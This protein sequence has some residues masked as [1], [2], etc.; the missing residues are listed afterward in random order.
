M[1]E[2]IKINIDE[3]IHEQQVTA[4]LIREGK[5]IVE[6]IPLYRRLKINLEELEK[7][8]SDFSDE[9]HQCEEYTEGIIC[10]LSSFLDNSSSTFLSPAYFLNNY[11][12]ILIEYTINHLNRKIHMDDY[13][14]FK[15]ISTINIQSIFISIKCLLDRLVP[16]MSYFYKGI[17]LTS[18]FGRIKESNKSSGLMG[19]VF[20]NKESD[21]LFKYIYDQYN[22]WIKDIVVP[23]DI[24][25]HYNDMGLREHPTIDNRI[26]IFHVENKIFDKEKDEEDLFD[27]P[28]E[29]YYKS[30]AE[31]VNHIYEFYDTVFSLLKD[32]D[33]IYTKHHFENE[34]FYKKYMDM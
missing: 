11:I 16:I 25:M 18:T 12:D 6:D 29:H 8:F 14:L 20:Q 13:E 32:K 22:E 33:I 7:N 31:E 5:L 15:N 28:R 21:E 24:V 26:I 30:I 10:P 19:R 34:D 27:L 2:M 9:I 17:S 1:D 3:F 4:Q 23:R